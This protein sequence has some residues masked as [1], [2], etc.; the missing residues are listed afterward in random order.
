[1]RFPA[2]CTS[3]TK[4]SHDP[5]AAIV[6]AVVLALLAPACSSRPSSTGS[7]GSQDA[8]GS[9]SSASAVAFS[10]CMRSQ[11]V[12]NYPDPDNSGQ[13]PKTDPQLLGVSTSQYDAAQQ[14]CR[15]LLPTGGSLHQREEQCIV[16]GGPCSPSLLQQMLTADRKF[17]QCMRS[18]GW[19]NFP[20]PTP[21]SDGPVFNITAAGISDAMSHTNRFEA[22]LDVC[23]RL[24]G[25]NAPYVFG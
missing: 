11:G 23:E 8:G 9:S 2:D 22:T 12:P 5:T 4:R 18:H 10:A 16:T 13:L 14:A 19:L 21:Q 24:V 1:M 17:A 7:G 15:H 3:M 20:D 6:A 25:N